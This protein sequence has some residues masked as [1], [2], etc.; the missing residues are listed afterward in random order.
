MAVPQHYAFTG[1]TVGDRFFL[2]S[3]KNP[4]HFVEAARRLAPGIPVK[5][6][7][8]GEPLIVAP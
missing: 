8:P 4:A 7:D 2:K 6:I 1:G 5:V 3:D